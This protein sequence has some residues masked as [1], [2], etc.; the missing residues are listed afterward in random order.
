MTVP[1]NRDPTTR[2]FAETLEHEFPGRFVWLLGN[3]VDMCALVAAH[4]VHE[5]DGIVLD[6]GVSSMQLDQ[7]DRGF[8]F[9]RDGP[10]DMRMSQ[11]GRS[12]ADVVNQASESELADILYYYGEEKSSRRVAH[13]II[14]A[15]AKAPITGTRQ[16]AEIVRGVLGQHQKTDAATRSFQALR[17]HVNEE[18]DAIE[19]GL[20][21]AEA[22]LAPGGRLVVVT[23]HS[24]EDR[25][26]KRFF[27]SRCG[28]LGEQSRH[29]PHL[30]TEKA[31]PH[32]F[33]PRPAKRTAGD[34]ETRDNPRAR[35]ATLRLMTR[36]FG[37]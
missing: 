4:G 13:A 14:E 2:E 9:R 19:S 3:F 25:L 24:L 23:F 33:L 31:A 34:D 10:L 18:L 5:V 6:L 15:R 7:A 17:I 1:I 12:A 26:V 30:R 36:A 16:L 27:Q 8:S 21:A 22:M 11:A 20:K 29:A 32:F 37:T 28:N 35:S